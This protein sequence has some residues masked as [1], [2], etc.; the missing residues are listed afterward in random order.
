MYNK[1]NELK[2][3]EK[4]TISS[5]MVSVKPQ[6]DFRIVTNKHDIQLLKGKTVAVPEIYIQ[7][8]KTEGVI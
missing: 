6:K 5:G 3:A 2:V 8:L 1:K 4:A 7:N